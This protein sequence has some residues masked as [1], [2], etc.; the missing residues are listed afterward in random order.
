MGGMEVRNLSTHNTATEC[1]AWLVH[2]D[3]LIGHPVD[4]AVVARVHVPQVVRDDDDGESQR[5]HEPQHDVEHDSVFKVVL[6]GQI[7]GASWVTLEPK[8]VNHKHL[9]LI[10]GNVVLFY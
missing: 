3:L 1:N 6:V 8:Q 9:G 4:D 5:D 10:R 7:V 2:A